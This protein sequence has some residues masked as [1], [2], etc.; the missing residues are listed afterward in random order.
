MGSMISIANSNN[1][2]HFSLLFLWP[3]DCRYQIQ[4]LSKRM[5]R[6]DG[7]REREDNSATSLNHSGPE[8]DPAS[9][10]GGDE[11]G[12]VRRVYS[13]HEKQHAVDRP[14]DVCFSLS[15][16]HIANTLKISSAG[17]QTQG[18]GHI[19]GLTMADI[20]WHRLSSA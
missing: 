9:G 5:R 6:Q 13:V 8:V 19:I 12:C 3:L 4:F 20:Q 15:I 17:S 1:S 14:A 7:R 18:Q 11:S 10:A 2:D 16:R